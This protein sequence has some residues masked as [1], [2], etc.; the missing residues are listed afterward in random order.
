MSDTATILDGK[1]VSRKLLDEV[2]Q[3]IGALPGPAKPRL[4]VILVG[5]DPASEVYVG[6]KIKSSA[7]V[8]VESELLRFPDTM[9]EEHLIT[10]IET[11][12]NRADVDGILVQLPLPKHINTERVL[13]TV[14]PDKDVDGFHPMNLGRLVMGIEPP[15]MPCTPAGI[16]RLM[17]EYNL[18]LEGIRA[19]VVGRSNIVGKPV[20]MMLLHRNATVTMCHSRTNNLEDIL[21][22]SDLVI[23]A[24]GK[25]DL[26]RAEMVKPGAIVV[27]VGINRTT[28]G[29]LCGDVDFE[30]CKSRAGYITPV[31]GGVGPMTIATLMNNTLRLH[32]LHQGQTPRNLLFV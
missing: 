23:A 15:A 31:P 12:N 27:D 14:L 22:D 21:R 20:S 16:I 8:G 13:D 2:A 11:L 32:Q 25:Q 4:S 18:K 24:A 10:E 30:A 26:I 7:K 29:K 9:A 3:Q 5:N 6:R 28:E 17:D 1:M 19:A